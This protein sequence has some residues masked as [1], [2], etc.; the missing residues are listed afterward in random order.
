[1]IRNAIIVLRRRGRYVVSAILP[2]PTFSFSRGDNRRR[3]QSFSRGSTEV[4]KNLL[5]MIFVKLSES[6]KFYEMSF[7]FFADPTCRMLKSL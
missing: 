6:I 1:M 3:D 7:R 4:V 5:E 2:P